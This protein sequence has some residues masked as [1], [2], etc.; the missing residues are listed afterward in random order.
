MLK[1]FHLPQWFLQQPH[2]RC[3]LPTAPGFA[4]RHYGKSS[5][6][7]LGN[8]ALKP[9]NGFNGYSVDPKHVQVSRTMSW[10][11][12]HGAKSQG[13]AIRPDGYVRVRDLVSFFSCGQE[14]HLTCSTWRLA[15]PPNPPRRR[16]LSLREDSQG[17]FEKK[18][19]SFVR[20][21]HLQ[22]RRCSGTH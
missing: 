9:R 18:I 22:R 5:R 17:G 11:L 7:N 20:T 12:R 10:L 19:P 4:A 15:Q 8:D 6:K 2:C 14:E 1:I 3:R 16:F 13:V 21:T